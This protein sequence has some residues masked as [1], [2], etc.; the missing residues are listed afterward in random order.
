M[1]LSVVLEHLFM[2]NLNIFIKSILGE[3][4]VRVI[5]KFVKVDKIE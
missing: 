3:R 4:R 1:F 2:N 5:E